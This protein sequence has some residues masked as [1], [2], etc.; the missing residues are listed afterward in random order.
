MVTLDLIVMMAYMVGILAAGIWAKSKV[1]S[2]DQFLVAGRSVGQFL[3]AGT[4][5]AIVLGGA[6]TVGGVKLGYQYGISGMWFVFMFGLGILVL[7]VVLVPRIL[8]LNLYTVPEL[9]ERR[10]SASARITGGLVMVAYDFMVAVTATIAV[11][12]VME[13]I[14]GIPR[15]KAI[16]LSSAVMVAYSVFGGMWS[17]TVTDI[18]QFVIKTVGILFIL[19]PAALFHAGGLS[20]MHERLPAGF[21][22]LTHIGGAKIF[23]FFL[24]YFF[25]IIIGQDVWQRVFTARNIKVARSG[26]VAVGIYCLV[27]AMAGALIGAAGHVLLPHLADPDSAFANIV[28]LVLPAGLRGL[29]LAASLAAMMSTASACLLAASTVLLEDVYLRLRGAGS[30]GSVKQSRVVTLAFGV[31]MTIVAS[32]TNDVIAAI[33]V[34]YDLLVGALFVPVI[35]AMLWRRGTA[36]GAIASIAVSA[37]TVVIA[38]VT[39]GIDSDTPIYAGFGL[40]L[41]VFVV[42]S[43]FTRPAPAA[44]GDMSRPNM[45]V[46]S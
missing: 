24:L 45:S 26:G 13:V 38:L 41:V 15:T 14:V 36:A 16:V 18:V 1:T 17:L 30:I 2:Q 12:A 21:F 33:T 5:A 28:N 32:G 23:S 43:L 3:Y 40:S 35:G 4:L 8:N 9:L 31:L 19:L 34:A 44:T 37:P 20:A 46:E 10:Y 25:G 29:V 42:I 39:Q 7:S 22:S 11:G 27:Y 6:S